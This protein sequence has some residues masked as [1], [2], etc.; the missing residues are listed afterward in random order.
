MFLFPPV[1]K[2]WLVFVLMT[3]LQGSLPA[4]GTGSSIILRPGINPDSLPP[5]SALWDSLLQ[6]HVNTEGRVNYKSFQADQPVL[7]SFLV[8]MSAHP[9]LPEWTREEQM[10]Y[11]INAYNAFT[12]DLIL[13]NYPV[14][15]IMR[16]DGGKT[17]DVRRIKIG[18]KKY[19]L[20]QI[21]NDILRPQ[22]K[23][24]RI[25]F[26]INC[27]ARSCPPLLN[28]AYTAGQLD[29]LL[30]ERTRAFVNDPAY[31]TVRPG[32][33]KISRIFEWYAVDFGNVVRFLNRY[34]DKKINASAVVQY[35]EYDWGLNIW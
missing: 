6:K 12:I 25:H 34:S 30:D 18:S 24:P 13:D 35:Q 33:A 11:W 4:F 32:S 29:S 14:S 8:L 21:E 26:A 20:N 7:D 19:S 16:L 22:F 9:P 15:S 17:W 2:K 23:D 31:N 27:A 10:A 5:S 1:C 3:V 28:R